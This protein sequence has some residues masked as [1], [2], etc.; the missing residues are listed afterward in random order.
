MS[1]YTYCTYFDIAYAARGRLL[2]ESLRQCGDFGPIYVLA[3]DEE[4]FDEVS[5][6]AGSDIHVLTLLDLEQEFPRLSTARLDR[7]QMEYVFTLTPWLIKWTMRTLDEDSWVTYLDADMAFYSSTSPIYELLTD[8]SIGIVPHR[9]SWE[10]FWRRKYG[11]YNVAWVSF[12]KDTAG[13]ACLH[14]WADQCHTWC[15]D[16]V[17]DGRFADQG[18]LDKFPQLFDG[19][20]IIDL[21]GADVAPWNIRR[22]RFTSTDHVTVLVDGAA[23]I[24]FHFHGLR[25]EGTLFHFRHAPYLARTS[26]LIRELIY[27]PY[28]AKLL[29]IGISTTRE[30]PPMS[31]RPTLLTV[32]RARR[33]A[34]I[35]WLGVRR[36]DYLDLKAHDPHW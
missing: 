6:W 8:A 16:Q 33:S 30:T 2:I 21:P 1:L 13:Q 4:T 15:R 14:W 5:T 7:S 32:L 12:K 23:L 10:Q 19:V 11:K 3:L 9:F 31:R 26:P 35:Q 25:V 36:G 29:A 27:R 34:F 20:Q 24:F 18:Y 28:C 17:D 22:Y